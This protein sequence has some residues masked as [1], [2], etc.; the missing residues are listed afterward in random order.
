MLMF[1]MTGVLMTAPAAAQEF[2][3]KP[4][5]IISPFAPG[6]A[7][8]TLGRALSTPLS[9]ALGQ[10]VIVENQPGRSEMER[11]G[12]IVKALNLKID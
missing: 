6:G 5:R 7:T 3:S 10:N 8:D 11:N 9:R 12:K 4:V 1:S 2:P